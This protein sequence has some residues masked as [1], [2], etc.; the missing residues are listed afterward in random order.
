MRHTRWRG[1]RATKH[2]TFDL[3][4]PWARPYGFGEVR[5]GPLALLTFTALSG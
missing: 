4:R 1:S 2:V 3:R 5:V